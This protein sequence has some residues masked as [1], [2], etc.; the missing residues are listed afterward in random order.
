[1]GRIF[2]PLL[3]LLARCSKNNLIR[4]IEFLKAENE[5]L[6]KRVPMKGIRLNAEERGRLMKLGQAIGP[7]VQ[8]L[9]TIVTITAYRRWLREAGQ[10]PK[11][12]KRMGRPR[13]KEAIRELVI[14]I[15]TE[16]GWGYTRVMGEIKKL[17]VKPPSRSTVKRLLKEHR[18]DPPPKTPGTWEQFLKIHAD[19]LWQ[20]D[21]FSK[22]M[23]TPKG[24]RQ[25]FVL[26]FIHVG[27]RRVFV[28]PCTLNPTAAWMKQ[29]SEA[30]VQHV[31]TEEIPT[32]IVMRD[33]DRNYRKRSFDDVMRGAGF[34]V[35]QTTYRSPNLQAYV[36]RFIQSLGQE[37]MDHFI[38]CG[39]AHVDHLISEFVDYYH[40]ERPHQSKGNLPLTGDWPEPARERAPERTIECVARLGGL[41]KSYRAA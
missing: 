9:I 39:E 29:Q 14:K 27:S 25:F 28:S 31:K 3:F 7:G 10:A 12:K 8:H 37:C 19:T 40:H 21:F 24:M 36:E 35:Q 18:P 23:W 26:V 33:R 6:R 1:M 5:M 38:P 41:L 2:H 30:F 4:Q 22:M 16:T 20:A 11:P 32:A 13:T 34:K 17:G 15:G